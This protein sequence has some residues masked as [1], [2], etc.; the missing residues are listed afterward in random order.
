M[1]RVFFL[2]SGDK[3]GRE[4]ELCACRTG[5]LTTKGLT[6]SQRKRLKFKGSG[7]CDVF[8]KMN[9]KS[10]SYIKKCSLGRDED[11]KAGRIQSKSICTESC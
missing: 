9:L 7:L 4:S 8:L 6:A 2:I 5:K 1:K 11:S 10:S 3:H